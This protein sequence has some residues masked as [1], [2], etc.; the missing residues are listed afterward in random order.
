M[1]LEDLQSFVVSDECQK[2]TW[3]SGYRRSMGVADGR[4]RYGS[5]TANGTVQHATAGA[6]GPWFPSSE[7]GGV[8][9]KLGLPEMDIPGPGLARFTFAML[10]ELYAVMPR[11]Y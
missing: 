9:E 6:K 11:V 5:T 4:A 2:V 1:T 7:H 10:A 3:Q 8:I